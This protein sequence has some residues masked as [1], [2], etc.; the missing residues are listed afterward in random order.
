MTAN[1]ACLL[2]SVLGFAVL[3]AVG[4]VSGATPLLRGWLVAVLA[5]L[6]LPLGALLLLLTDHLIP[7]RWPAPLAAIFEAAAL[8]LPVIGVALLPMLAMPQA[9]WPWAD[10]S[11][12]PSGWPNEGWLQP[13]LFT[14]RALGIVGML[15]LFAWGAATRTSGRT[16]PALA[17][18]GLVA[19]TLAGTLAAFDWGMSL[20]PEFRSTVYGLM[21]LTDLTLTGFAF[22]VPMV[23]ARQ[24]PAPIPPGPLAAVLLSLVMLWAYLAFCQYLIVWSG[25]LPH[26]IGWYLRRATGGW[27]AAAWALG[28]AGTVLFLALLPGRVR[29]SARA[30][31]A[32]A[33]AVLVL[34][35]VESAWLFIPAWPEG[36]AFILAAY[37]GGMAAGGGL[38][39]LGFLRLL[40]G[41]PAPEAG[42]G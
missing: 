13:P 30:L 4:V 6:G 37:A 3:A 38:W 41:R 20:E 11:P 21:I 32:V 12:W 34:R 40:A 23:L 15:S 19:L 35:A 16:R 10:A 18:L 39:G 9:V 5:I 2:A 28:I 27:Q 24:S 36:Q 7:R 29:H 17:A 31:S 1:R 26:E 25:D 14:A 22:A 42:H 8:T 33:L